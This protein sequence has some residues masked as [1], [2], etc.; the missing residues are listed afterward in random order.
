MLLSLSI[1]DFVIVDTLDI[2]FESGFTTLT[3]ETGA[4]KSILIDAISLLLG[5]RADVEMIREGRARADLSA[6]FS[7]AKE[8]VLLE[9]L[10]EES[11]LD[12][13]MPEMLILRRV[14]EAHGRSKAFINGVTVPT[15][16][17]KEVGDL[18]LDIHGQH[19]HQQLLKTDAQR[20]LLDAYS[21]AQNV[22][23]ETKEAYRLWQEKKSQCLIAH[24]H[25]QESAFDRERLTLQ[26]E[27]VESLQF[28]PK[29]WLEMNQIHHR[30][31]H[32]ASLIDG[33][34]KACDALSEKEASCQSILSREIQR[35]QQLQTYDEEGLAEVLTSL[36]AADAEMNEAIYGLQRYRDKLELDPVA[37]LELENRI[38]EIF[39]MA[40]K[41][42]I[43]PA[44]LAD[45]L[46]EWQQSLA[47]LESLIDIESLRAEEEQA[48][49]KY[50]ELA[51]KL[52]HQ[53]RAGA[54]E[55][56]EKVT[57]SMQLLAMQGSQFAIALSPTAEPQAYGLENIE[58]QVATHTGGQL[59]ALAK[60]A[61]GGELSR[62]SLALQVATSEVARVPT[63][64]FDEVDVG[65]GGR[66]A[67]IVGQLLKSL[68][69]RYQVLC[70]THL[71]Q[72]AAC[73]DHQLQVSKT[74]KNDQVLTQIQ[75]LD[76]TKRI[77]EIARMLGGVE[78]TSTTRQHAKQMLG[79]T[80]GE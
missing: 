64:I 58:Y 61:S 68:G 15:N 59:R 14:I 50:N 27:E 78:I 5:D 47:E 51:N 8:K 20:I 54:L 49:R 63:L 66:V 22:A 43:E 9:W 28:D 6:E 75:M 40:K 25:A 41:Y 33:V 44:Q 65:I 24:T 12:T 13:D 17:L 56:A 10:I 19:A 36:T 69:K 77:E 62:I 3:G 31:H 29:N 73:A 70:I 48:Q 32:A 18:L 39:R 7:I 72:V 37:L 2:T 1:R 53:R 45:K 74:T 38:Q 55:L 67:E 30:L 16:K 21:G 23:L 35:L 60:V 80:S 76:Q 26:I 79:L 57:Q 11:L 52:S 34:Q 42:H 46:T 4:G 71:P